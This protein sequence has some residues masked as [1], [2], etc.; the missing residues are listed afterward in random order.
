MATESQGNM[1][2][3]LIYPNYLESFFVV[4]SSFQQNL[5]L[6]MIAAAVR[7]AGHVVTVID[8]TAERLNIRR[9]EEKVRHANPDIIGISANV[10]FARKA[11]I[12]GRWMKIKFS[13]AKI[14]FG[15]PWPTIDYEYLLEKGA[16]HYVVIGEGEKTI[17]ELLKAIENGM[18]LTEVDGIAFMDGDKVYKTNPR[19]LIDDLDALPFPAWDL[20]PP[21]RKYFSNV[22]GKRFYPISTSRGCPFGCIFC[23]KM[24]HG[25]KIR[26]RSIENVITELKYLKKNFDMDEVIFTDD[27]LNFYIDR[28]EQLCDA[29]LNLDFKFSMAFFN[30]LRADRLPPRLAW[31]LSQAGTYDV[32]L[33]IECGNQALVYKIGKNLNLDAVRAA[34]KLLKRLKIYITGF[35]TIGLPGETIQSLLETKQFALELDADFS[36]FFK[37]IP[38]PGTRLYHIIQERGKFLI[39]MRENMSFYNVS[40]PTYEFNDLPHELVDLAIRDM[41]KSFYL[42]PRKILAFIARMRLK[43]IRWQVNFLLVIF[44]SIFSRKEAKPRPDL[45]K[46]IVSKILNHDLAR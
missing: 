17:V 20:F 8:A 19:A 43:N 13:R 30:G 10:S 32:S 35:F 5:G 25:Y 2:V 15:G 36:D 22:K 29:I 26:T 9:L 38:F 34:V 21:P 14:V 28:A 46:Y 45:K 11:T 7:N 31:K 1:N 42:R 24:V 33:G 27:N 39:D 44:N 16:A 18:S 40:K 4:P 6:A 37:V 12:T 23:S 41:N 3:V